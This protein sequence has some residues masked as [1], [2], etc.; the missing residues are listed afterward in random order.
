MD[1]MPVYVVDG[2]RTPFGSFGG[3]LKDITATRL[4][5]IAAA[6]ALRRSGV[7]PD[8]IDNVVFGNVIQSHNGAPYLARHIAL[9][10]GVPVETPALTVNRLCGSGLQAVV[11]AAKDILLGESHIA[12]A[13]GAESMSQAPYVLR[14]A[15]FGQ[16]MGDAVAADVLTEALTDCRGNLP[17]GITAENLA[18]RFGITREA[19]DE[20]ACLSQARAAAAR[21]SGRLAEEIVPVSVPGRKGDTLVEQDEHIRP[22]TTL[23]ALARLKPA[24]KA[25]GTVTA[26]NASGINDG[27]AAVVVASGQAVAERGLKPVA[28]ILGWAVAGVEPAYMG[29]GPVPAVRKALAAA[30]VSFEDVAL[31]EVNEAFAA[32]YLSVERELGLPR[33]RTNVNGGAIALGHPI[34]ASGARVLLTLAYELRRRGERIGVASLCIG[35]GQGIAM[36]IEST[37]D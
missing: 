16:R 30:G 8:A 29:I 24:F 19:Q 36:V 26:G 12:L 35:G 13:G 7:G 11:T 5:A 2:A 14:G 4:G 28:R 34:G 20:F 6:E 23:E 37:A 15:R 18:E 3:S 33:E 1:R 10:V 22:G 27:A 31:W 21:A 25:G 9:D 17:M 32:Q